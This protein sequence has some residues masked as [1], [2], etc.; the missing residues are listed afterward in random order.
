M[1]YNSPIKIFFCIYWGD[2]V[3]FILQFVNMVYHIDGFVD[4]EKSLHPWDKSHLI[5]VYD[6][7]TVLLDLVC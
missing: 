1:A 5:T 7:F 4:T 2:H 6:P 3:I